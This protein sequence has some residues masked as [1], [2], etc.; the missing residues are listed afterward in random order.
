MEPV[1]L[2]VAGDLIGAEMER[3]VPIG[4]PGDTLSARTSCADSPANSAPASCRVRGF[5][6]IELL[7]VIGIIALLIALLVPVLGKARGSSHSVNCLSNLRQIMMA[8]N[9]YA[10]DNQ[11]RLPDPIAAQESW[12]SL[13]RTYL[14]NRNV[15]HCQSDGGLFVKLRSSYDWRDSANPKMVF[16]FDALPDW[17]ARGKIN[18]ARADGSAD[19]INYQDCLKDLDNPLR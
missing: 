13:L 14:P 7:V 15:Y 19:T 12:E 4:H 2:A 9:L 6:L 16:T 1:A 18:A 10:N 5:T 8:F 11:Q 3:P 17:H